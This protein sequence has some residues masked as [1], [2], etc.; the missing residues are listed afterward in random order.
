[1]SLP[2]HTPTMT[3]ILLNPTAHQRAEQASQLHSDWQTAER[4]YLNTLAI[5]AAHAYVQEIGFSPQVQSQMLQDAIVQSLADS[6]ELA[7]QHYGSIECRRVLPHSQI[8]YIPE[9]VWSD[10]IAFLAVRLDEE[11]EKAEILG[12]VDRVESVETPLSKLRSLGEFP[13]YLRSLQGSLSESVTALSQW[14]RGEIASRWQEIQ[15]LLW[16]NHPQLVPVYR[17]ESLEDKIVVRFPAEQGDVSKGLSLPGVDNQNLVCRGLKISLSQ[18]TIGLL[19]FITPLSEAEV[20]I[21]M[22]LL[23]LSEYPFLPQNLVFSICD[24]DDKAVIE[25]QTQTDHERVQMSFEGEIGDRFSVRLQ[26]GGETI[27]E[28]F[29][30]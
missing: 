28:F 6:A 16:I 9:E 19:A 30:V 12:F 22:L 13:D 8:V 4:V 21:K 2:T 3:S 11:L 24:E 27:T 18:Q 5:F 23:P 17:G 1:M 26:L 7:I 25:V 10:R 14:F 29:L 15:D 20:R